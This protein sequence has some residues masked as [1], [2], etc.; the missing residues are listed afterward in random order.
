MGCLG[1]GSS[2]GF[3]S[4]QCVVLASVRFAGHPQAV[5]N[6]E[7][8]ARKRSHQVPGVVRGT[9]PHV[10]SRAARVPARVR[11]CGLRVCGR[12]GGVWVFLAPTL[13]LTLPWHE[14]R[15]YGKPYS[16]PNSSPV[17]P[18][19]GGDAGLLRDRRTSS[20]VNSPMEVV[21]LAVGLPDMVAKVARATR[22]VEG[23]MRA[24]GLNARVAAAEN[25]ISLSASVI[26]GA[27]VRR[28]DG[29]EHSCR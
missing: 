5:G 13:A 12:A 19:D 22:A 15:R 26:V 14:A 7:F 18:R 24:V 6:E 16:D 25:I 29:R 2:S 3:G 8:L 27:S 21:H 20:T 28:E 23:T 10:L 17:A 9:H 4:V 1:L 11:V